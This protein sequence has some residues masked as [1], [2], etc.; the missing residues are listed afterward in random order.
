MGLNTALGVSVMVFTALRVGFWFKKLCLL[1][2]YGILLQQAA[3][4][5]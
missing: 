4:A 5:D 3:Q 2:V 1:P